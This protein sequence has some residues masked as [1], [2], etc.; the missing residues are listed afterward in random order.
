MRTSGLDIVAAV[1][2]IIGALNWGL[3]GLF[4]LNPIGMLLG[5]G[6]T[7]ERIIYILVGLA[8]LWSAFSLATK[9]AAMSEAYQHRKA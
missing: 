4:G 7:V 3:I 6:S 8:G 1:L 5:Y 9:G 2:V